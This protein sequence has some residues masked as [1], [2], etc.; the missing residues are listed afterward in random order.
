MSYTT[1][2][3][4]VLDWEKVAEPTNIADEVEEVE[5]VQGQEMGVE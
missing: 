5:E 3:D 4:L 1:V 2:P